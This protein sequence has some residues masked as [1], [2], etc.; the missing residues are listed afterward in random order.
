MRADSLAG[1]VVAVLSRR[2]PAFRDA[3]GTSA[4]RSWA[5]AVER[6]LARAGRNEQ[7]VHKKRQFTHSGMEAALVNRAELR[8][9][10]RQLSLAERPALR[11]TAGAADQPLPAAPRPTVD[12]APPPARAPGE[13]DA[14][15]VRTARALRVSGVI[16]TAHQRRTDES[17]ARRLLPHLAGFLCGLLVVVLLTLPF[18]VAGLAGL[19]VWLAAGPLFLLNAAERRAARWIGRLRR[20]T[21]EESHRLQPVWREV[22]A[23]AGQSPGRDDI[24]VEDTDRLFGR[25]APGRVVGVTSAALTRLSS[26]ELAAVLGREPGRRRRRS[27]L[28]WYWYALPGRAVWWLADVIVLGARRVARP[29]GYPAAA[30]FVCGIGQLAF[31]TRSSLYGLPWLLL[32]VPPAVNIL[33]R[34]TELR[35]DRDAAE[36]G[37]APQLAQALAKAEDDRSP[38]GLLSPRP[39]PAVRLARLRPYLR[40]PTHPPRA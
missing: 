22:L 26:G 13:I 7:V 37:F 4:S 39:D 10:L 34:R 16:V 31:V 12:P 29:L 19:L 1:R 36:L 5:Q 18:G 11:G 33:I 21:P 8:R 23:R 38:A 40:P 28:P 9:K 17:A 20:P 15:A 35:A 3:P 32:A 6:G 27:P 30:L 2:A 25:I 14:P 24:W